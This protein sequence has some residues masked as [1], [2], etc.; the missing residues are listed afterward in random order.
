MRLEM[1]MTAEP[2]NAVDSSGAPGPRVRLTPAAVAWV[3]QRRLQKGQPEAVLRVGVKGGGCAGYSYVTDLVD[4]DPKERD[5]VYEF[6]GV[7]VF[8]D[9]RS[10]RFIDGSVIDAK[11]SLMYQGLKFSNPQEEK[12]CGCGMT[13]SVREVAEQK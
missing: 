1:D 4:G 7:R 13:F 3:K 9:E 10:L 5:I 6:D 12:S 2:T 8:V 11:Q